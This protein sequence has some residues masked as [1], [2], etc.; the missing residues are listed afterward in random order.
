VSGDDF[1]P[2]EVAPG[3]HVATA[4]LYTTTTTIVTGAD[5]GCLLIDPAVTVADLERLAGWL[6]GRGL[7]PVAAWSTHPHWDHVLWSR[8]LGADVVRYATP[9]ASLTAE[10]ELPGLTEGVQ[11]SAPG[12]D[13]ALFGRVAPLAAAEVPWDGPRAVVIAHDAHAPGHGA[14]FLPDSGVLVAG[15][16]CSDIEIPLPDMEAAQ[17]PEAPEA[18]EAS[19]PFGTNRHGLGLLASQAGVRVVVPGH[20]HVGDAAEFSRR[21]ATDFAYLDAVEAGRDPRD[22]RLAQEWLRAEHERHRAYVRDAG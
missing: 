9:R 4:Q 21:V 11:E 7:R 1:A 15:D 13:L 5:G 14:L 16:M 2:Q 18:S 8:G 10:R 20:G 22:P 12:H 17:A 3:V 19:D 6:A